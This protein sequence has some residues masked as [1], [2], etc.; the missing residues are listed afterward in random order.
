MTFENLK[1]VDVCCDTHNG[2]SQNLRLIPKKNVF[3]LLVQ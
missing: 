3:F 1:L 2:W